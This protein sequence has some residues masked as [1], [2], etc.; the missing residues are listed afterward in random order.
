MA[1]DLTVVQ[2]YLIVTA[3]STMVLSDLVRTHLAD[4]NRLRPDKIANI[5]RYLVP[6]LIGIFLWIIWWS[7]RAWPLALSVMGVEV[8]AVGFTPRASQNV[9]A[10]M[11]RQ[12]IRVAGV[13]CVSCLV[14]TL[15]THNYSIQPWLSATP[16]T[17][18]PLFVIGIASTLMCFQGGA[19]VGLI[20]GGLRD[21]I[22]A[23]SKK[24]SRGAT[25]TLADSCRAYGQD[26]DSIPDCGKLIGQI[27]RIL[28]FGLVLA[29]KP[30]GIGLLITAKS[31]LRY[32]DMASS[33]NRA[34][35]EYLL[36]DTL[37]SFAY[38]VLIAYA[39]KHVLAR[40]L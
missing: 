16:E 17:F 5:D 1:A 3:L 24:L 39:A 32:P 20:T 22:R 30:E 38:A 15:L 21:D 18:R 25:S 7:V 36:V 12:L 23:N 13:C 40:W 9:K 33:G 11:A 28:I 27:E 10:F 4:K 19:F 26:P 6:T 31:I 8:V 29:G 34:R 37:A 14:P 2:R 35:A